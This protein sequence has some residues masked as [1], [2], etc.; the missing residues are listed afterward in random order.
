MNWYYEKAGQRQGP[1]PE[2][3]LDRFLASGEIN[4]TTLVWSEGMANWAPLAQARPSAASQAAVPGE[5]VPE[6][7]IRCT[8]TGRF[9]PPSEIV[10]IDGK[11]YSAAA[12]PA[13]LQGVMESGVVPAGLDTNRDGPASAEKRREALG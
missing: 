9:F 13:V 6:G 3:E 12:K 1:V 10:Y 11:A 4:P 5:A 2:A 7:W 8:A